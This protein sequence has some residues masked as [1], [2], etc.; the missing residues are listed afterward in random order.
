MGQTT[1]TIELPSGEKLHGNLVWIPPGGS[2]SS[3][4][5]TTDQGSALAGGISSGNTG[6]YVGAIIGDR[7]TTMRIQLLCNTFTGRCAGA[8]QTSEGAVYDIQR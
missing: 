4:I 5:V 3:A 1:V 7:G 6:M 8:G 2:V